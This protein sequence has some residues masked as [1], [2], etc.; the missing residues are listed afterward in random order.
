[1]SQLVE[2]S[3]PEPINES[4]QCRHVITTKTTL[5]LSLYE[6]PSDRKLGGW[7]EVVR[8]FVLVCQR[9]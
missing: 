2:V 8:V 6:S 1:M 9:V 3:D 5:R 4:C 7:G